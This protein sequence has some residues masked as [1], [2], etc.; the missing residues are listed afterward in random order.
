MIVGHATS[1]ISRALVAF[2][3]DFFLLLSIFFTLVFVSFSLRFCIFFSSV[4]FNGL[5]ENF[6]YVCSS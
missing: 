5:S 1:G 6:C 2:F 3:H 4:K